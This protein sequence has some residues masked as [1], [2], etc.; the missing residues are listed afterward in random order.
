[1]DIYSNEKYRHSIPMTSIKPLKVQRR[2]QLIPKAHLQR[3]SAIT[4]STLQYTIYKLTTIN[5]LNSN[6]SH[7]PFL[8]SNHCVF[9]TASKATSS[10]IKV[11]VLNQALHHENI[12]GTGGM[13]LRILTLSTGCTRGVTSTHLHYLQAKATAPN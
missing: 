8:L 5:F 7:R 4:V 10:R 13:P 12:S 2:T 3:A 9:L 11:I 1:M 6:T